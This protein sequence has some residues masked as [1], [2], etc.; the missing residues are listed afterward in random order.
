MS[1]DHEHIAVVDFLTAHAA[2]IRRM[3]PESGEGT[4]MIL[5]DII[6]ELFE[7]LHHDPAYVS[8]LNG[9]LVNK[10]EGPN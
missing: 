8:F 7:Y 1:E 10:N 4:A 2:F 5:D 6:E 9:T 3:Y